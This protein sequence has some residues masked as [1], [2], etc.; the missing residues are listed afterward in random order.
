M[1]ST[2]RL[3]NYKKDYEYVHNKT[4]LLASRSAALTGGD[5]TLVRHFQPLNW[6]NGRTPPPQVRHK[7]DDL[8]T[9]KGHP[10]LVKPVSIPELLTA[11]E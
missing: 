7:V 3:V 10:F 11:I 4:C 5:S 9:R 2:G 6:S 8:A 1:G